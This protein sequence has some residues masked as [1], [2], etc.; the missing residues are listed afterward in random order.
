MH[1]MTEDDWAPLPAERL[2]ERPGDVVDLTPRKPKPPAPPP[3]PPPAP[4][5]PAAERALAELKQRIARQ[6]AATSLI[7]QAGRD[8]QRAA[9]RMKAAGDA[10]LAATLA[11]ADDAQAQPV[12]EYDAGTD[13]RDS[14]EE[15]EW[16]RALPPA[17]QERLHT[18][19]AGKRSQAIDSAVGQRTH[20]NRRFVAA[21]VVF[22]A[23][24]FLGT[25]AF[26]H[27]TIA[28]GIVCGIWWRHASP[29]RFLDP[30]RALGCLYA[31]HAIAMVAQQ[32][33]VTGPFWDS[34]LVC[35]FAALIGFDGE[36]RR[37]GGF[38]AR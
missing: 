17:E 37:S 29:D 9:R 33:F 6:P 38:D 13:G 20:R 35:A 16:F 2:C 36:C 24:M 7:A 10:R 11:H 22:V 28:A 8:E 32:R 15:S 31:M 25:G 4:P 5:D 26:W 18:S 1:P 12:V 34:I 21:V 3:P 14:R 27:A 19:W 23:A 30:L